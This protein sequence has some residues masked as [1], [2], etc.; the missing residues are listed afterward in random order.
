[1]SSPRFIRYDGEVM[2]RRSVVVTECYR[3]GGRSVIVEAIPATE[4]VVGGE[5]DV[6]VDSAVLDR[7]ET[8]VHR[9]LDGSDAAELRIT[10]TA[11]D[12]VAASG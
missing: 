11:T 7:L 9:A 1:M 12:A 4:V 10:Y 5:T 3:P 2:S 8:L 6:L